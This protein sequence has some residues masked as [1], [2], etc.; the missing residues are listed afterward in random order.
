M[1]TGE[2]LLAALTAVVAVITLGSFVANGIKK[3]EL[4]QGGPGPTPTVTSTNV[5]VDSPAPTNAGT[6]TGK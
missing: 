3:V 4:P 2:R 6:A 5:T 1:T